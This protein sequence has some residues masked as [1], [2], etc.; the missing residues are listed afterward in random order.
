MEITETLNANYIDAQYQLWKTGPSRVSRDWCFFFEGFELADN[1]NAGQGES[2]CTLDQSLRQARVE[3]LKYR[4]RDLGHL[5]ACLDPLSECAF[6]HPLLDLPAFGLTENDLDQTFYTRRFSQTQ[7][8]PLLEIIQVLRET[9]CRSVGVEFMHLQDPAER[10]WLQDRMEPVRNQPA[11]ERDGKIRILNKLCQAAVFERFLHKKYMGQTRFSLEGGETLIPMLDALV[12]HISEQDCQEIVLGMAH[13]GRLN[14]LTNVL[15]K[16][17]DDIFREFANT[18]N[19]DSL[20][21]S[22]DMKYHNGY[23]NDIHL[24]N[25]R[26]L[27][28]FINNQIGYTTLPENA[29]STR[30]STDIAKMLMVPIFHVHGENPE[31]A[32]HVIKLASDYRMTFGKDVVIDLVC[33]RRFGHNEGDEPY[34]TQ[35]QMYERIRG[36][37]PDA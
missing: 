9:Y 11:L 2:V 24:A 30:Y 28:A 33:Y 16:S 32:V 4:Y 6:I 3:S 5:L 12:L 27:R 29:R 13:R 15:Y 36:T 25:Y 22:G 19:P 7:Q 14:V 37:L 10:R 34:F 31:A 18:Y 26:T 8:A 20:V 35:P 1:R 17:Y 23:L 21:G